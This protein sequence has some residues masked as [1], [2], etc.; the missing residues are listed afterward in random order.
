MAGVLCQIQEC[1]IIQVFRSFSF[2]SFHFM[3][4]NKTDWSGGEPRDQYEKNYVMG[5]WKFSDKISIEELIDVAK[6][7][8]TEDQNYLQLYVRKCSKNQYGI[9][10]T[11]KL[12]GKSERDSMKKYTDPVSDFLKRRFG[13]DLVGWDIANPAWIIK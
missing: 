5:L 6:Q 8:T 2:L 1:G 7:W 13:N 10:F 4:K 9:G 11:Y 12:E 3:E